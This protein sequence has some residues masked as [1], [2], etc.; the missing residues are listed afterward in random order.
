MCKKKTYKIKSRKIYKN[1]KQLNKPKQIKY[2]NDKSNLNKN[3]LKLQYKKTKTNVLKGGY[4]KIFKKINADNTEK[5]YKFNDDI[6]VKN[7]A[8]LFVKDNKLYTTFH[9]SY[10]DNLIMKIKNSIETIT[11]SYISYVNVNLDVI[12]DIDN[13][14][15]IND[16]D[17]LLVNAA[18]IDNS[19]LLKSIYIKKNNDDTFGFNTSELLVVDR[20]G[21]NNT[22]ATI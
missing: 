19:N 16:E 22:S 4:T 6:Y 5:Y 9:K 20:Y 2:K 12:E 13:L 10:T 11:N 21:F 1:K 8:Q 14:K 18:N 3:I 7:T 17:I 15:E